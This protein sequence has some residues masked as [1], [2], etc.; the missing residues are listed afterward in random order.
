MTDFTEPQHQE[1][2]EAG[3]DHWRLSSPFSSMVCPRAHIQDC[4]HT[5]FEYLQGMRCHNLFWVPQ[6]TALLQS[7]AL[8]IVNVLDFTRLLSL[9]YLLR[10]SEKE[11]HCMALMPSIARS[12]TLFWKLNSS[13]FFGSN[14]KILFQCLCQLPSLAFQVIFEGGLLKISK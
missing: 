2:D 4:V 9:F 12:C 3:K 6:L 8:S 5:T 11:H 1:M 13:N 10:V 14:F 7:P